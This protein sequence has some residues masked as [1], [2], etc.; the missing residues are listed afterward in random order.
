[1]V[2][3]ALSKIVAPVLPSTILHRES[4]VTRLSESITAGQTSLES[5]VAHHKLILLCAPAGYGKTTLLADFARSTDIP[6]CWYFLDQNDTDRYIFL[7]GLLTSIRHRF[8]GFGATLDPLLALS[9]GEASSLDPEDDTYHFEAFVDALVSALGTEITQRFALLLCNY[10]V[11]DESQAITNLVNRLLQRMPPQCV[12]IIES[13]ATPSIEFVSLL[14]H[15]QAIGLGSNMLRMNAEEILALAHIQG[16]TPPSR[17]EAEQL[18][19]AFDGWV[20][21]ILLGTR[22]GDAELLHT[23]TRTGILQGLPSMR[24][25]REKLFA[26]LVNEIFQRQPAAYTFLKEAAILEQMIPAQCDVLLGITN[27]FEHLVYLVRQG[28]FVSCSDEGPEPVYT[29]H[30]VLRELLCDELRHRSPERFVELHQRAAE[31]FAASHDYHKAIFHALAANDNHGAARLII[32]AHKQIVTRE[33][34]QVL[35]HWIDAL[36]PAIVESYPQLLLIQASIYLMRSEYYQAFPLLDLAASALRTNPQVM[37]D[38]NDL[39]RLQAEILTLRSKVLFQAGQYQEAQH[40][41]QQVLEAT[42]MDEVTLRAEAHARFGMCANLLGDMPSSIEQMQK[43]LLLWGRH[44]VQPQTTDAHSVLASSYNKMGN[45]ALAEHH[46]SCAISYCD[47]LHDEKGKI[48]NLICMAVYKQRQGA[49]AEAERIL[50]QILTTVRNT[51]GFEREASYILVNLGSIYQDEGRYDQS[52]SILEEGLGLARQLR[53]NYLTNCCL[54]YLAMTYLL[55]GD[56]ST[57]TLLLSETNLPAHS[58]SIG[59]EQAIH[60]LTYGTILL[61]QKR[62]DEACTFFAALEASLKKAGLKREL[63]RVEVRL[64]ACQLAQRNKAEAIHHL[65]EITSILENQ[66]YG[67]VVLLAIRRYPALQKLVKTLPQLEDLRALLHIEPSVQESEEVAPPKPATPA[68]LRAITI[69]PKLKIQ[70]FG[71]P[72][73]FLDGRPITR[74]RMA[75]SMELFFFLLDSGR[76]MR[77]EQI[78]TALWP[79]VDEQINQT[80]HSTIYYLRKALNESYIVSHGGIYSLDLSSL[81]NN[82]MQYDVSLF[83]EQ[84]VQAKQSLA[85]E[86]DEAAKAALL[87]MV[88]LYQG[89]YVQPFYSDWCSLRRDELR[90]VYLEARNLLAHIA[91]RQEEFDESAIHWQHIL[92]MDNWIEEAHYGLMRYYIRTGKRGLALR[93]YQR[94]VETLQQEL[95]ARPGQAVQSLYQR[96]M[97]TSEQTKKNGK[98]STMSKETSGTR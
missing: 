60:D 37:I 40:L 71:E 20:A 4:L 11:V 62:Y 57:A 74:W 29:C 44:T 78:I 22:L 16:V 7:S 1:M 85:N 38:P 84:Y 63:L 46:L 10:H 45:F 14:A 97:S 43:A 73:V 25:E 92:A 76:P 33:R 80:F 66:D 56:A 65:D 67:Q 96:I 86:N 49:F 5:G 47:Q 53:D 91:W 9:I 93:Q 87:S 6:C 64:G 88:N 72:A 17:S 15:R 3:T 51:P 31:L 98:A 61:H 77:K 79:Q 28:M 52:L 34:T 75:R 50:T 18:A 83:K 36:P 32:Q 69:E 59:Y 30:P 2:S 12:L 82:M 48:N 41:C 70:A 81:D 58:E 13:R 8:P 55:M 94:C 35:L 24:V 21:G 68:P 95:G 19:R 90:R 54:C 39:P 89:D 23:S 26:Y 27:S 42:P